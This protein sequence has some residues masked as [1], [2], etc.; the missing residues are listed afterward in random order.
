M[1]SLRKYPGEPM[2]RGTPKCPWDEGRATASSATLNDTKK[3]VT[4]TDRIGRADRDPPKF[5]YFNDQGAHFGKKQ[6]NWSAWEKFC[7]E[8]AAALEDLEP[9]YPDFRGLLVILHFC[10]FL[11]PCML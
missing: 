1:K 4:T 11:Q 6:E 5:E 3:E 8:M 7:F 2:A 9:H 10:F